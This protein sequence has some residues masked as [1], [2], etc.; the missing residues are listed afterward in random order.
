MKNIDWVE[1]AYVLGS[2]FIMVSSYFYLIG[3]ANT[4]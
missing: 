2:A 4:V 1:L 3:L